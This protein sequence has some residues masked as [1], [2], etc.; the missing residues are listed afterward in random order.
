VAATKFCY[1][2][3]QRTWQFLATATNF[4]IP[5]TMGAAHHILNID[6]VKFEALGLKDPDAD[7]GKDQ[8]TAVLSMEFDGNFSGVIPGTEDAMTFVD[9]A[10]SMRFQMSHPNVK[11]EEPLFDDLQ[12]LALL[13]V[14]AGA[15][16][17]PL[18]SST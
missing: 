5:F 6:S 2:D 9:A 15:Y 12:I 7:A 10:Y 1:N 18:F 16:T 14:E 17:R 3:E 13:E 11:T 4:S 8:A